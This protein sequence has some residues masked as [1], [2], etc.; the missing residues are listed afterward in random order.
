MQA[1]GEK[2]DTLICVR[3]GVGAEGDGQGDAGGQGGRGSVVFATQKPAVQTRQSRETLPGRM[4]FLASDTVK[5]TALP[6][7]LG[8]A[9]DIAGVRFLRCLRL[10]L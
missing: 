5:P 3:S 9:D 7:S 8:R 4:L 10:R 1:S 2:G 6:V